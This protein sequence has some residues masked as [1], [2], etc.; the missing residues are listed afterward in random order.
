MD[1]GEDN[2]DGFLV[3]IEVGKENK[4]YDV[5]VVKGKGLEKAPLNGSRDFHPRSN[6]I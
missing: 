5:F 6:K 4:K 2:Q 1:M 3:I